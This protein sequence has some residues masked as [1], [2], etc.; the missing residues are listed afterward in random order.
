MAAARRSVGKRFKAERMPEFTEEHRKAEQAFEAR[1]D[2]AN[3]K[4]ERLIAEALAQLEAKPVAPEELTEAEIVWQA[5][6]Q[7]ADARLELGA[8]LVDQ[9][10]D[11]SQRLYDEVMDMIDVHEASG[12]PLPPSPVIS[13]SREPQRHLSSDCAQRRVASV[14]SVNSCSIRPKFRPQSSEVSHIPISSKRISKSV[15][16]SPPLPPVWRA[17]AS[18][19]PVACRYSYQRTW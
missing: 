10:L 9:A 4:A 7:A 13:M 6:A 14:S 18:K 8:L 17:P 5:Q 1:I 2:I 12:V 15:P 3:C 16:L 11:R 19:I